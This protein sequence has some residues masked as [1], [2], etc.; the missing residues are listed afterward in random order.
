MP[1]SNYWDLSVSILWIECLIHMVRI[2]CNLLFFYY[3]TLYL[4]INMETERFRF[5]DFRLKNQAF[6]LC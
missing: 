5:T 6:N 3:A 1:N 4:I 2:P